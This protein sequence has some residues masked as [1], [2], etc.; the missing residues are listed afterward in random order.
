MQA[1]QQDMWEQQSA[2]QQPQ[3]MPAPPLPSPSPEDD[4][5]GG[6]SQGFFGEMP[7][8]GAVR[9]SPLAFCELLALAS[10]CTE[11]Q[12]LRIPTGSLCASSKVQC[13]LSFG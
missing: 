3:S 6:S 11:S 13:R 4:F 7:P 9:H 8:R 12:S 10:A 2:A 1:P 5:V